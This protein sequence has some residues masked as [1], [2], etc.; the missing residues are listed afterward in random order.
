M[1]GYVPNPTDAT[2]PT[3]NV[4]AS[5]ADDEFR[6]LKGYVLGLALAT[7]MFAQVRQ[8]ANDSFLDSTGNPAFLKAAVAG[9]AALDLVATA[10]PLV[11]NFAGGS[12][13][14]GSNDRNAMLTA[15][16]A[17]AV[18]AL[19]VSNLSYVYADYLTAA[20]WTWGSTLAPV[21]YG[22]VYPQNIG[23][24]HQFV[25]AAGAT[26][27]LDDFGNT[28]TAA[29]GAKVQTN[30]IKFGTGALGGAGG[31]N[32]LNGTTDLI[33]TSAYTSLGSGGWSVRAWLYPT[34]LPGAAAEA[35]AINLG[36]AASV[37]G[38][39]LA[40]FNNAGTIKFAQSLSSTGAANDIANSQQGTTT[41]VIN[42]WYFVE[43]TYD[44]VAGVYRLYVNGTQEASTASAAKIC[45]IGSTTIGS[46]TDSASGFVGYIDKPEILSYCQHPAGTV[47]VSPTVAPS[48]TA[49][50]YAPDFF[51]IQGMKMYSVTGASLAVATAPTL[52]S[53]YRTYLAETVM[54]A[55]V[56][57]S[58]TNYAL[59]GKYISVDTA[60]PAAGTRTAFNGNLGVIP[61]LSPEIFIR[62]YIAEAGYTPGMVLRADVSPNAAYQNSGT[63]AAEDKNI[64]SFVTG[65]TASI[66]AKNRTTGVATGLTPASWKMFV[67]ASRGW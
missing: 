46:R 25:G 31:V 9:G 26:T 35:V 8:C 16:T 29:G 52:T 21:Q 27:F 45:G 44:S 33:R 30:Q 3:G 22:K 59:N 43:I 10:R 50:G 28:W 38:V 40:I 2:Q 67:T 20:S 18:A 34:V 58:V 53:K 24:V 66:G 47:Y 55:V 63:V 32:V 7:G 15:D 57:S 1:P 62:N 36:N 4:D 19:P 48:I 12:T 11:V 56:P 65:S 37:F 14:T 49:A 39:R 17:N 23:T 64:L 13:G 60:V 6:A 5:T 61:L 42:T 54:G 51:D 41:P